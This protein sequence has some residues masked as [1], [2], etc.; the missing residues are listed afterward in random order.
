MYYRLITSRLGMYK[1]GH[2]LY[3]S[4]GEQGVGE[5]S[6]V[7][8]TLTGSLH[9][10]SHKLLRTEGGVLLEEVILEVVEMVQLIEELGLINL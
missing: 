7:D 6:G 2:L 1:T 9:K 8:T 3:P 10:T 4:P 5:F